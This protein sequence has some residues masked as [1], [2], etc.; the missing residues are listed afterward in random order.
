MLS[1]LSIGAI[2]P[3]DETFATL[4]EQRSSA[5][6]TMIM[7]PPGPAKTDQLMP[8][9]SACARVHRDMSCFVVICAMPEIPVITASLSFRRSADRHAALS[10][11]LAV[12]G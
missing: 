8:G 4:R 12:L 6:S 3:P 11:G 7:V 9:V 5:C 10:W 2:A 1:E